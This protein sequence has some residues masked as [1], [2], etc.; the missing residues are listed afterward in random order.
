VAGGLAAPFFVLSALGL[1]LPTA[2][3]CA[4]QVTLPLLAATGHSAAR[5]RRLLLRLEVGG[6]L[7]TVAL[8]AAAGSAAGLAVEA[9]WGYA[10]DDGY[11]VYD[12]YREWLGPEA[13]AVLSAVAPWACVVGRALGLATAVAVAAGRASAEPAPEVKIHGAGPGFGPAG[14]LWA[15]PCAFQVLDGRRRRREDTK[16]A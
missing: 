15:N 7:E 11:G 14:K 10:A 4:A 3:V 6:P 9:A 2:A 1:P 5:L 16:E 8:G 12:V 13:A